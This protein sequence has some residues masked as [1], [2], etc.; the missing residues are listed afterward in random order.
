MAQP[1]P[2]CGKAHSPCACSKPL[3]KVSTATQRSPDRYA[4]CI[5]KL[6]ADGISKRCI[7][8]LHRKAHRPAAS[9]GIA[10]LPRRRLSDRITHCQTALPTAS[11]RRILR[12]LSCRVLLSQPCFL[13]R[14]FTG[15]IS[16]GSTPKTAFLEKARH[17]LA[18]KRAI[19]RVSFIAP[20][21]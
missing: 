4:C 21:P 1:R 18:H 8:R 5:A 11:P 20:A 12:G 10:R 19:H 2:A 16:P 3:R 17:I 13:N 14:L 15:C 7:A 9:E 6:N